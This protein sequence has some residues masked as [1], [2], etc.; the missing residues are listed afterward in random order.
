MCSFCMTVI[1]SLRWFFVFLFCTLHSTSAQH[2]FSLTLL[3][4]ATPRRPSPRSDHLSVV[5]NSGSGPLLI[6]HGGRDA[7]GAK[8]DTWTYIV[9]QNKWG[10]LAGDALGSNE[11]PPPLY[12]AVGGYRFV[13]GENSPFLYVALGTSDGMRSLNTEMWVMEFKNFT[14]R[15]V[16]VDGEKPEPRFGAIGSLE[17]FSKPDGT[18]QPALII[19]HGYGR[20]GPLSDTYKCTFD[21]KDPYRASWTRLRRPVSQYSTRNPHSMWYQA[22]SFTANRDIVVFGGCY[23]SEGTGGICPN[24]DVWL[25]EYKQEESNA[26]A[27]LQTLPESNSSSFREEAIRWQ[28]LPRGPAPRVGAAMAQGL[29]SFEG[30]Y[31]SRLG[32]AVLYSGS[33]DT[34]S[35]P[36]D[37]IISAHKVDGSEIDLVSTQARTWLRERINFDGPKELEKKAFMPRKG[38]SLDIV[39]NRTED[40]D[41]DVPNEF[42]LF[43]GGELE[44]GQFSNELMRISFDGFLESDLIEG[45]ARYISRPFVHGLLMFTAWGVLMSAGSFVARY[46]KQPNGRPKYFMVH[47]LLQTLGLILTWIGVALAIQGRRNTSTPFLHARL[48]I[49]LIILASLQPVVASVGIVAQMRV[50]PVLLF[51]SKP[52]APKLVLS[53]CRLLHR[54]IGVV[55]LAM[56][57]LNITLGLFLIVA[58]TILWVHWLVFA[59]MMV[60]T[61]GWLELMRRKGS[62]RIITRAISNN[63]ASVERPSSVLGRV[64]RSIRGDSTAKLGMDEDINGIAGRISQSDSIKEARPEDEIAPDS[65]VTKNRARAGRY[66]VIE[67]FVESDVVRQLVEQERAQQRTEKEKEE[68]L[69]E[70]RRER[71][72]ANGL[73]R[74]QE[75]FDIFGFQRSI[76][77]ATSMYTYRDPD[78]Y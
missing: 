29:N 21:E 62:A 51:V 47:L 65:T 8:S 23:A 38:A 44:N 53:R 4:T 56:G 43:F 35:L 32:I 66:V 69:A 72:S 41:L 12:G 1:S 37:H 77:E 28:I 39:R 60:V 74:D 58:P 70:E 61:A 64:M 52:D 9:A 67:D 68:Q 40:D 75:D 7:H 48:G 14:W 20:S 63:R 16:A 24:N 49:A 18:V 3:D 25:L 6:I 36:S 5:V 34:T 45:S 33:Q 19:S 22:S 10:L 15:R 50:N 26:V 78:A 76:S 27:A 17:R 54:I 55:V 57:W 30:A 71:E 13:D 73:D 59:I 31:E 11:R 46:L 42:F 2:R